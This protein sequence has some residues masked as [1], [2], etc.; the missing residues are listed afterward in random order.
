MA[1][2][3]F[4]LGQAFAAVVRGCAEGVD[5]ES[6][7]ILIIS[8]YLPLDLG[9]AHE[10]SIGQRCARTC[11]LAPRNDAKRNVDII[12]IRIYTLLRSP[13]RGALCRTLHGVAWRGMG[14]APCR[15]VVTCDPRSGGSGTPPYGHYD[16]RARNSLE[17]CRAPMPCAR[18]RGP[19]LVGIRPA[20]AGPIRTPSQSSLRRLCKLIC[21]ERRKAGHPAQ[22]CRRRAAGG[23]SVR[24]PAWSVHSAFRRSAPSQAGFVRFAKRK[25]VPG[26]HRAKPGRSCAAGMRHAV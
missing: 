18:K 19:G 26:S 14:A 4:F 6:S 12:P 11:W 9:L 16:P 5:P 10:L 15:R 21:V 8:H 17:R 2:G 13:Q 24:P 22:G 20:L 3:H 23:E 7:D 25:A 1:S